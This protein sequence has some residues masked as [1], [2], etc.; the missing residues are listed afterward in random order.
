MS[1]SL[2]LFLTFLCTFCLSYSQA[3]TIL[4]MGDSLSA[5]YQ[6]PIENG[7]VHLL[8][9]RVKQQDDKIDIINASIS[10]ETTQGGVSRLVSLLEN[11]PTLVILE[12]GANDALRGYPLKTTKKNLIKMIKDSKR[13][14]A[15]V[16]L[17]GNQ[18]PPNYGRRYANA[19]Y[20]LYQDIAQ[21]E[22]VS[23]V[24]FMLDNVA[25]NQDLMLKDGLHPN[26]Q[27]QTVVLQN[28]MPKVL[29]LLELK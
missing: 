6:L 29:P 14:G 17:I 23:L 5:A 12:L 27:G 21:Q 19:F 2:R 24:P 11:K 26:A 13:I 16:L 9:T 25:L 4:V 3:S 18:I 28:I 1:N 7:W 10:G 22:E 15:K 20:A 8:E